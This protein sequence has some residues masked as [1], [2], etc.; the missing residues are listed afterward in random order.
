VAVTPAQTLLYAQLAGCAAQAF[1]AMAQ[2]R[3]GRRMSQEELLTQFS[4]YEE[5][6]LLGGPL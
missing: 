3:A 6:L 2:T 1:T 5:M 4:Q